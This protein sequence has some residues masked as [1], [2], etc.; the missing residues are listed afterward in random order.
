MNFAPWFPQHTRSYTT[1]GAYGAHDT[2]PTTRVPREAPPLSEVPR[3]SPARASSCPALAGSH[4]TSP[5]RLGPARDA[6]GGGPVATEEGGETLGQDLWAD[7][8][9]RV[10]LPHPP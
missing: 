9:S 4:G 1:G 2:H 7:V 10:W 6:G 5:E 3:T 8:P